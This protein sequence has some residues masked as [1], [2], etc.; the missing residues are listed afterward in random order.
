MGVQDCYTRLTVSQQYAMPPTED[1]RVYT[2]GPD[3]GAGPM[4]LA[5]P[6]STWL[7]WWPVTV[8]CPPLP[9]GET[10]AETLRFHGL[11]G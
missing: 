1:A 9:L 11:P 2:W 3:D 6:D 5:Y 4:P 7:D 10:C 8:W